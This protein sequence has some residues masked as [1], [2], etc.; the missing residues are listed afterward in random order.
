MA[1]PPHAWSS[2]HLRM[3][4]RALAVQLAMLGL[5]FL[6]LA[7]FEAITH[8]AVPGVEFGF[9][10]TYA[11]PLLFAMLGSFVLLIAGIVAGESAS[12]APSLVDTSSVAP[13]RPDARLGARK[14]AQPEA[15]LQFHP[16]NAVAY[17]HYLGDLKTKG[18]RK[19]KIIDAAAALA[20]GRNPVVL[21]E[22]LAAMAAICYAHDGEAY[23]A[24]QCPHLVH[25]KIFKSRNTQALAFL[26][27]DAAFIVLCPIDLDRFGPR[28]ATATALRAGRYDFVP[29]DVIWEAAPRHSAFAKEWDAIRSDIEQWVKECALKDNLERPF[30][31]SGHATG[32]ALANL[33]AYEFAKRGRVVAGVITF[34]APPPGGQAFGEEYDR[35][36]LDDRTLRLEFD[37]AAPAS[38]LLP[39]LYVPVGRVWRLERQSLPSRDPSVTQPE[40]PRSRTAY[41]AYSVQ[42]RYGLALSTLVYQRLRELMGASGAAADY[43]AAYMALADHSSYI[44]GLRSEGANSVFSAVKDRPV[45][46]KDAADLAALEAAHPQY[47]I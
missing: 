40:V 22:F 7:A 29:S 11:T 46:V 3:N 1:L 36:G 4:S 16:F 45:K 44:R 5:A 2:C 13:P 10:G 9:Y 23:V 38:T 28:I 12:E 43:E 47:L 8:P 14:T 17:K 21:C 42:R 33:A 30:M 26:F 15:P 18:P 39:M 25:P 19:V 34:G 31:F 6:G 41:A 20:E 24:E 32:G 35:L 37:A 27:E